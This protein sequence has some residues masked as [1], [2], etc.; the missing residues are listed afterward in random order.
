MNLKKIGGRKFLVNLFSDFILGKIPYDEK[1]IIKIVDCGNFYVIKGKT[2]SKQVLFLPNIISEFK[3]KFKELTDEKKL[4]HT[5][6]LIEYDSDLSESKDLTHTFHNNTPNCSYHYK[7]VD[8]FESLQEKDEMVYVSEFPHGYS[9]NQGRDLYYYAKHIF[10]N[11]PS[12]YP[13]TSL[14]LTLT[15]EKNSD[16]DQKIIVFDEFFKSEDERLKSAIL[17]V[18]DFDFNKLSEKMK[19]VDWSKELTNPLEEHKE[20]KEVVKDFIIL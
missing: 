11:I 4:T 2:S 7:E 9:L 16:G 8:E 18:F 6:D 15:K 20:L 13:I 10:Y 12:N 1:S 19:K 14:T 17:D 5:I 3:E